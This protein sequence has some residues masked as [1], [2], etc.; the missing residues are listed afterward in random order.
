MQYY[1]KGTN[2]KTFS[3]HIVLKYIQK[4]HSH[5]KII[6][7]GYWILPKYFGLWVEILNIWV[8]RC[9]FRIQK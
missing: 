1:G 9:E 4:I 5:P 7:I 8:F 2:L 3:D 6:E